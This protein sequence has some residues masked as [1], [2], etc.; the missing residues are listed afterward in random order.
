MPI[1]VW[2]R[3]L[4]ILFTMPKSTRLLSP[5]DLC[6]PTY[7]SPSSYL[8]ESLFPRIVCIGNAF[9]CLYIFVD[10]SLFQII[11]DYLI[12]C[13]ALF[14]HDQTKPF[15][16]LLQTSK[17]AFFILIFVLSPFNSNAPFQAS[18]L[19]FKL[20]SGSLTKANPSA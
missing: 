11:S 6:L 10:F 8:F 18:G 15:W 3:N 9:S 1:N 19:P 12:L 5:I 2:T 4:P 13:I 16:K 17:F 14:I 20:S 7:W